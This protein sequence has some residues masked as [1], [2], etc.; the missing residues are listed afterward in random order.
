MEIR[1]NS[2]YHQ[3]V[4]RLAQRFKPMAYAPDGLIEGFYD[5]DAYNPEEGKFIKGL[6]F[7][8]E[9]MRKANS[10]EFDYPGCT[11]A[12]KMNEEREKLARAVMGKMTIEQLS[13][14]NLFY[15]LMGQIS[16]DMLEK[17]QLQNVSTNML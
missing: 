11:A 16:S 6:Q 12:Y 14:L 1:V 4:K 2:Y 3:G 10:D 7:H 13:D 9:R 5:P 17:K 15:H 8:P